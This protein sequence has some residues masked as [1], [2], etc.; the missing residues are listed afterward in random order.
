VSCL[1]RGVF[2]YV[3]DK[4]PASNVFAKLFTLTRLFQELRYIGHWL[5]FTVAL[6]VSIT[7]SPPAHAAPT[8][9]RVLTDNMAEAN[10]WDLEIHSSLAKPT[11]NSNQSRSSVLNGL[12]EIAY[13]ITKHW[14]ASL[15]LP[16]SRINDKW[17][18]TGINA[19]LQFIA[20]HQEDE[21]LYWGGRAEIARVRPV[22]GNLSWQ[23]EWRVILGYRIDRWHLVLNPGV[24]KP[25]TGQ[26][27]QITFEPSAKAIYSFDPQMGTGFEYFVDAG[28]IAHLFSHKQ[29]SELALFVI[30]KKLKGA[31]LNLGIGKGLTGASDQ[32]VAKAILSLSFE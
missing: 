31:E 18:G 7:A 20:P 32:W 12:A 21:G 3:N 19:E 25:H 9:I 28:P 6:V 1:A 10:E 26:D 14:E 17:Y 16:I 4:G 8:D 2:H 15:Q 5:G 11:T 22:N 13:G 29:R 23:T 27:K 30:D 24:T